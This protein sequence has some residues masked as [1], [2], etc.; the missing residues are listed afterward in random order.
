M[1]A[2]Y[3]FA[4]ATALALGASASAAPI[5]GDVA[6]ACDRVCMTG[7]VDRYLAALVRHDPAGLPLNRDVKFT[8]NTAR[9]KV[10]SEG[11]AVEGGERPNHGD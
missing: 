3:R 5:G 11:L 4:V 10:G 2:R 8:E 7:I 9:L 1:S 6:P